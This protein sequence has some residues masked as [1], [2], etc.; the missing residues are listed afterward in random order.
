MMRV[1]YV[2][3]RY[4]T[5]F[6]EGY[7]IG[8]RNLITAASLKKIKATVF[9]VEPPNRDVHKSEAYVSPTLIG[10]SYHLDDLITFPHIALLSSMR[11][12][13]IIHFLPNLAGDTY[14]FFV[15]QAKTAK[16]VVH[17][18]H[19]YEPFIHSPLSRF[20]LFSLLD[21]ISDYAFCTT[22]FLAKYFREHTRMAPERIFRVPFPIDTNKYRPLGKKEEFRSKYGISHGSVIAYVGQVEPVRGIF[23]LLQAFSRIAK[24][25]VDVQLVISSP[26]MQFEEKYMVAVHELL[27]SLKLEEK[28]ILLP[29]QPHLEEI[30]NLAD[31]IVFP[32]LQPY[33]RTDPPLTLLEAMASGGVVVASAVGVANSLIVNGRNG[34]LV[35]CASVEALCEALSDCVRNVDEYR[36]LGMNARETIMADFSIDKVGF[37]MANIYNKIL[38][39]KN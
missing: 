34:K 13:D 23:V 15:R 18:S 39:D 24:T 31:V 22:E 25:D 20:R 1:F 33:Y 37:Q 16:I 19:P 36:S 11:E 4:L 9:T 27:K 5:P 12:S 35:K 17:F 32:Y 28:V 14:A 10:E 8:S 26:Q 3:K 6:N 30:Y 2:M 29:P 7:T 38:Q 21:K